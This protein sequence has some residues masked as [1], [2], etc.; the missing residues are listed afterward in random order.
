MQVPL[1]PLKTVLFPGGPLPLRIFETRYVDMISQCM[2]DNG[3]FGVLLI[4]DG[5]EAG[6]AAST[7][8]IGTLARIVDF[9]QGSDGLLG[10]TAIGTHKF[11]LK[12]AE[13][14]EDGLNI[15]E[16]EILPSETPMK[17]PQEYASLAEILEAILD[18][19]GRLYEDMER[20]LD[21]AGWVANRFMEILP[22]ALEQKQ[23]C[24]ER[25]DCRQRLEIVAAVLEQVRLPAADDSPRAD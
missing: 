12:S 22:I 10:V 20:H 18:D 13:R 11:E 6:T 24:L 7:Y 3:S 16:I 17:L 21:D 19:L 15:G 9:Y 4:Q 8:T 25:A 14:Q 1:F 5:Q 2:K 23:M